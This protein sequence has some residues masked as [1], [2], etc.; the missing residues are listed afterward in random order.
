MLC[1]GTLMQPLLHLAKSINA[2]S[3]VPRSPSSPTCTYIE[4]NTSYLQSQ[5]T[6]KGVYRLQIMFSFTLSPTFD[7]KTKLNIWEDKL[8]P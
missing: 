8:S 5:Y 3:L 6:L 7:H 4:L 2:S 1:Q